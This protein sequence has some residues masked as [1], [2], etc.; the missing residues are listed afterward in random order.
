MP[1]TRPSARPRWLS[2]SRFTLA[3]ECPTK[4]FYSGQPGVFVD[5]RAGDDFLQALAEGGF[6]VGELAKLGFP[7]GIEVR[8]PEPSGQLHRTQQLLQ[9]DEVTVFEAAVA[10]GP[11][12]ARVDVLRRSGQRLELYEVKAKSFDSRDPHALRGKK[13][14]LAASMRPY[15]L[16]VAFQRH[17]LQQAF[18]GFTVSCFLV[19]PDKARTASVEGL[20]QRFRIRRTDGR[21]KVVVAPGTDAATIGAPVLTAV[22]VDE[23]IGELLCVPLQAPGTRGTL[24]ELAGQWARA[25]SAGERIPP[26]VGVHCARCEFRA[27]PLA[28]G[29]RSG[30]HECWKEATGLDVDELA[31]GTVLDLWNS[32]DRQNLI[33]RGV[34]RLADVPLDGLDTEA[35][36]DGLTR[37]Q[38]QAMQV[39]G[40]WP[41]RPDFFTDASRMRH[42][43]AQWRHPWHFIDFETAR[44]AVPFFAGQRPYA[45]IAFQFSHHVVD[46]E[47]RVEHRSQF[48]GAKPGRRPNLDFVRALEAAVGVEGTVF[49]WTGH[50]RSTL[51]AIAAELSAEPQPPP[52][53]EQLLAFV[54]SLVGGG[55]GA[56]GRLFDLCRL[57]E[58]AF[59][60]PA[61]RGSSSIKKLLPAV[62]ASSAHLK[63]RFTMPIYGAEGGIRSLNFRDHAWWRQEGDLVLDPYQ[64]LPPVFEGLDAAALETL[65]AD[66]GLAIAQGGMAAMAFASLQFE[67]LSAAQR[68]AIEAAL[69]RYCELDTLAMVLIVEAWK[70]WMCE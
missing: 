32:R 25:F 60:H 2:K 12:F 38:R 52:D 28:P 10:H 1:I 37:G 43:M 14:G 31:R 6:Q 3:L 17:V 36:A 41:G 30:L 70:E 66:E 47:G 50:E 16:D 40:R 56:P 8:E 19:M 69:L 22:P 33:E 57:A 63:R 27:D 58:K 54:D 23:W 64:L 53:V 61:S 65:D 39:T 46:A 68:R 26:T 51:Q 21:V 45:N 48:L 49:M 11:L 59:F 34:F 67:D 29:Q 15:L 24:P 9:Q 35:A 55:P 7:G 4:L 18:P 13:G 42:E 62:M 20:N 5:R 44:V